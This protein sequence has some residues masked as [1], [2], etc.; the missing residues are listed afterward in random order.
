MSHETTGTP[1][2][3]PP[4]REAVL[5]DLVRLQ[6]LSR[7]LGELCARAMEP[8]A[9]PSARSLSEKAQE[10]VRLVERLAG[11]AN[12]QESLG[13]YREATARLEDLIRRVARAGEPVQLEA[14]KQEAPGTI[15]DWASAVE[16]VLEG[17]LVRARP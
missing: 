8:A 2:A 15:H 13:Q 14:L 1:N 6:A 4:S 11:Y 5:A 3:T 10:S 12:S 9:S 16:R 7:E 17:V